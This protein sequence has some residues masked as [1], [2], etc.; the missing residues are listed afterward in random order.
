LG[1]IEFHKKKE[2]SKQPLE[3]IADGA[4]ER[5]KSVYFPVEFRVADL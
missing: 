3:W 1:Y 4:A 2:V 5:Y